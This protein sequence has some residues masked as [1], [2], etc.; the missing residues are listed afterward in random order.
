MQGSRPA[1]PNLPTHNL[2]LIASTPTARSPVPHFYS[3]CCLGHC[4]GQVAVRPFQQ[5]EPPQPRCLPG[6][7]MHTAIQRSFL[8]SS[9][10][11]PCLQ[12]A[13]LPPRRVGAEEIGGV[14]RVLL[15]VL[16]AVACTRE[17]TRPRVNNQN[18]RVSIKA[19][20]PCRRPGS[21]PP[22]TAEPPGTV[23]AVSDRTTFTPI[24]YVIQ[25]AR[26]R[27]PPTF[28]VTQHP[29]TDRAATWTSTQRHRRHMLACK[30]NLIGFTDRVR[31]GQRRWGQLGGRCGR[32]RSPR[33]PY[34]RTTW[35]SACAAPCRPPAPWSSW[36]GTS[37]AAPRSQHTDAS[38]RD[39]EV[40]CEWR[41]ECRAT[42]KENG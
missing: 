28:S 3:S 15:L 39:G 12:T 34:R 41:G 31:P 18:S 7:I 10:H 1:R 11:A 2:S 35:W 25:P 6:M 42:Q 29:N 26:T 9:D 17:N 23:F 40:Q 8:S 37:R 36:E 16:H 24:R 32:L 30:S 19:D 4:R 38:T 27:P 13:H 22:S 5:Q 33:H 20:R 21:M 14:D